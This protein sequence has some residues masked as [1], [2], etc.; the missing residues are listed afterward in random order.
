MGDKF[1]LIKHGTAVCYKT[2]LDGTSNM[3]AELSSGSYFGEV[4]FCSRLMNV[5]LLSNAKLI[6]YLLHVLDFIIDN[7]IKTSNCYF[8]R[9]IE[10][11]VSG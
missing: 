3:V 5:M 9:F 2:G 1:Y 8:S 4:S 6:Y 11:L 7:K 10:M